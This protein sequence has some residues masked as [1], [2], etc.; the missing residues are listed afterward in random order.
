[1]AP[2]LFNIGDVG[3]GLSTRKS[4]MFSSGMVTFEVRGTSALED[5]L[6]VSRV[7]LVPSARFSPDECH[8]QS[9]RLQHW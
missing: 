7:S 3:S 5:R 4:D 9:V 6:M 2:E 8:S 1:M